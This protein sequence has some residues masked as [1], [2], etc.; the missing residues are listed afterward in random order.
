MNP[1]S[2]Y[3]AR[4]YETGLLAAL[5]GQVRELRLYG[6]CIDPTWST[7]RFT[8]WKI[9]TRCVGGC[10]YGETSK[11]KWLNVKYFLGRIDGDDFSVFHVENEVSLSHATCKNENAR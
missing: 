11:E 2:S 7:G 3:S 10:T 6:T 9:A 8:T 5:G 4:Q 1:S